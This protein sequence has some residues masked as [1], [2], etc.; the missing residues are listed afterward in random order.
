MTEYDRI[1]QGKRY[2]GYAFTFYKAAFLVLLF[3]QYS[4]PPCRGW[5]RCSTSSPPPEA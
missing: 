3:R 5:R 2:E 4:L 1:G